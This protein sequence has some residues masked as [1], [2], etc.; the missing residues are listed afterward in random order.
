MHT[1][2]LVSQAKGF[3]NRITRQDLPTNIVEL[4]E[5]DLQ[6]VV[7]GPSRVGVNAFEQTLKHKAD[8]PT[9]KLTF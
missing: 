3:L 5:E 8:K 7:G 6:Q 9:T 4:S 2:N 1:K